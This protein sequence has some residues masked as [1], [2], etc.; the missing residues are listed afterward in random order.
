MAGCEN[1]SA[2]NAST[3]SVKHITQGEFAA[4]VT[5][6]TNAV[7]VEFY[8]TWCGPC[9]QLGPMLDRLASPFTDK[10]KFVKVNI[11]ESPGLA[12]NY[13]VQGVPTVIF[14]RD[15]KLAD[16]LAGLPTEA[17]LKATLEKFAAGK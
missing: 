5:L 10:I 8:A 6:C 1:P 2:L 12:Q 15:G 9:R 11:D 4:E 7:V 13:S 14:F 3:A 17:D 16:R